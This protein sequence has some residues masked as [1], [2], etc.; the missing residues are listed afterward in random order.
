MDPAR[1]VVHAGAVV[2]PASMVVGLTRTLRG[3]GADWCVVGG[4]GVDA[5]LG[6]QTREHKDL[7]VFV[8]QERLPVA[9]DVLHGAGLRYAY[10]WEESRPLAEGGRCAGHDS[11]F[12]MTDDDGRE[13]DVHVIATSDG[14]VEPLWDTAISF[15]PADL[16][17]RGVV[18]GAIVRCLAPEKQLEAHR[19]YELPAAHRADVTRLRLLLGY[20]RQ[21]A[22]RVR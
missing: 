8:R 5:L 6:V 9:L 19:G 18:A 7:D 20:P 1:R 4:W 11:A 15:R 22:P 2:V 10:A 12:V 3:C 21:R 14:R 17:V 13:L 16:A